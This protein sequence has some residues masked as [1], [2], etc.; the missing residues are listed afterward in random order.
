MMLPSLLIG[1]SSAIGILLRTSQVLDSIVHGITMVIPAGSPGIV[2]VGLMCAEMI[3][4]VLLTSVTAKAA[5][6]IPIIMPVAHIYGVDGEVVVMGL[7]LGSGMTNMITPTNPLLLAFL[8]ASKTTYVE[9]LRFMLP[10]FAILCPFSFL[11][12]YIIAS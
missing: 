10:L 12:M 4:G 9:W 8:A 6:S 3:F 2:A 5:I 1:L 11:V 7:L